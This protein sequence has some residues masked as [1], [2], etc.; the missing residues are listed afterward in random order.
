MSLRD[1]LAEHPPPDEAYS[2]TIAGVAARAARGE[3]LLPAVRELL[4]EFGLMQ[5]DD[6]RNRA[7]A[8][9]S[10]PTGDRRHDAFL[11]ALAEH[12]A[13]AAGAG[14]GVRTR[15]VPRPVVV[16]ERRQGLPRRRPRRG[17]GGVPP[18]GRAP[19]P[20]G[21][22]ALLSGGPRRHSRFCVEELFP[23]G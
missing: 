13:A 15:E 12:L 11:G 20:P 1:W 10:P 16:R 8:E 14:L 2:Q 7:L 4:D 18:E 5:T 3:E 19:L 22:R 9:R 17:T 23:P 6:Q 21:P